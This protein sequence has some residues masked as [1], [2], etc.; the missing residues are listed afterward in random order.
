MRG[1]TGWRTDRQFQKS[2]RSLM[3]RETAPG[4]RKDRQTE[5]TR[6]RGRQAFC[7]LMKVRRAQGSPC[8]YAV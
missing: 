7:Q 8:I 6:M 2:Y 1:F 5:K 3:K 4:S